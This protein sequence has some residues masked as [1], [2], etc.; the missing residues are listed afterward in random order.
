MT[1]EYTSPDS[2]Q[3]KQWYEPTCGRTLKEGVRSSW[4]GHS[5]LKVPIPALFEAHVAFNDFAD[6]GTGADFVNVFFAD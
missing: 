6:I 3:P 2:P 1:K 4:N 5:P